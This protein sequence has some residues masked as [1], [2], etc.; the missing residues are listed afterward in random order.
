MAISYLV[1]HSRY[2]FLLFVKRVEASIW[3]SVQKNEIRGERMA[4]PGCCGG[5][6]AAQ[7]CGGE[8]EERLYSYQRQTNR[9]LNKNEITC[10]KLLVLHDLIHLGCFITCAYIGA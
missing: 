9:D 3:E 1:C 4:G 2:S 7:R 6:G 10:M 8:A 5:E